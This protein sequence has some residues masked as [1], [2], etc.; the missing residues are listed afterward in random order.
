MWLV[1]GLGNPGGRYERTR[2]NIGFMVLKEFTEKHGLM[3][4]ETKVYRICNSFIDR[5]EIIIIEPLTLMNR[6]GTAVRKV[7][8]KF[9][10]PTEKIM[11]IQDDMDMEI[12]RFKIRRRGS[13]G[14]HRGIES[15]IQHLGT[16]DFIR[17]KIGIGRDN[18]IPAEDYVLSKFKRN[19][20]PLIREVIKKAG[21]AVYYIVTEGVNKAMNRFN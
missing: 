6:S 4:K 20:I 21:E 7:A 13:S 19:E 8:E 18:L 14:G 12:G 10:I 2:H 15:I 3:F 17:I 5:N 1:V 16:G 9:N 11:V